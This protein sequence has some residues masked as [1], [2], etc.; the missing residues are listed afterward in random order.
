MD[1]LPSKVA[2]NIRKLLSVKLVADGDNDQNCMNWP[3]RTALGR[4]ATGTRGCLTSVVIMLTAFNVHSAE[5]IGTADTLTPGFWELIIALFVTAIAASVAYLCYGAI[6][7]WL[8]YWRLLA[9]APLAILAF[10]L[11]ITTAGMSNNALWTF[12]LL[13]WAM[14]TTVYLVVLFTARRTFEKAASENKTVDS[15]P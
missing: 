12:E 8:G 2:S 6:R 3:D 1:Q 14:A 13:A 5:S 10:W 7:L 11:L 15:D 9:I 4:S